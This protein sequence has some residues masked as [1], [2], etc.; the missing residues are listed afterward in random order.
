MNRRG[1]LRACVQAAALGVGRPVL[2]QAV[3]RIVF[4]NPG[5]P[6]ERGTGPYWR[7]VSRFM[8]AAARSLGLELEVLYAE[9]DHLLMLRQAQSVA[10]RSSPP[11]YVVIVNE[12]MAAA[13]M[14]EMLS[15][16]PAKVLVIHNDLTLEQ[17]REIGH[18][19]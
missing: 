4:L 10:Q 6:E 11:D 18:E 19:R 7:M 1:L 17:R 3:V 9:R 2:G 16:S 5:E 12:K 15:R 13:Q 14:I 8:A